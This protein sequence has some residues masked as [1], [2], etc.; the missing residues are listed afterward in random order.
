MKRAGFLFF[1]AGTV[2][3]FGILLAEIFYPVPYSISKNMISNLGATPPPN[4][5]SYQPSASIFDTSMIVAGILILAGAFLARTKIKRLILIPAIGMGIGAIGVGIFPAYHV[6][7][8]P[9]SALV[10]FFFGGLAALL[11]SSVLSAPYKYIAI[12][13]GLISLLFL[14]L[15]ILLPETVVPV[16]GRGGVERIVA[17]SEVIWLLGFGA[18]HMRVK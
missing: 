18:Y 17:Y 14:F 11:S 7:D 12:I 2:I 16:L 8:H 13:L 10:A 1:L 15:G 6:F 5:V 4:S 3:L 9:V